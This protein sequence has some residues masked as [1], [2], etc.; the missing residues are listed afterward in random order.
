MVWSDFVF[1]CYVSNELERCDTTL[2]FFVIIS[3][4]TETL[5]DEQLL[6]DNRFQLEA[7][8]N[9]NCTNLQIISVVVYLCF[10]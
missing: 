6:F 5:T 1:M 10:K 7:V 8:Q 2:C 3:G 9:G 4:R